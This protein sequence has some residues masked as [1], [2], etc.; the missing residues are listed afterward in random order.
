MRSWITLLSGSP[1]RKHLLEVYGYDVRVIVP[2]AEE[3]MT[4]SSVPADVAVENAMRKFMSVQFEGVGLAADTIVVVEN[5][6]LGKPRSIE[7]ARKFLKML[8]GKEHQV[9]TGYVIGRS[10]SPKVVRHSGTSV[11]FMEL[12]EVEIDYMLRSE[13]LLDKAGAYA[14]QGAAGLFIERISGEYTN[15]IGLPMPEI[16][17]ALRDEFNILP[18]KWR[19]K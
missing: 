2:N 11:R 19:G 7:E 13:N 3:V 9:I 18:S 10:G 8:S 17:R 12:G 6:I 5:I 14:I 1:R 15:V 4:H 16:Y